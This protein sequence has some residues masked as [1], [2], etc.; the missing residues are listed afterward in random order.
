MSQFFIIHPQNPQARLIQQ[1]VDIL[2]KGGIIV[3]PTD[4]GYAIG[5]QLENKDGADRIRNIRQLSADHNFTLVCRN[6]SQLSVYASVDNV[7][8]RLL[9][10]NT[11][12]A[13]TF[14][15]NATKEVPK[16]LVHARRKTIGIRI[17]DSEIIQTL[18]L[19]L[20]EPLMS[21][22]LI[23]PN[24]EYPFSDAQDILEHLN[25]QVDLVIDGGS[26]GVTP[27]T[28]IELV[29]SAPKILRIGKGDPRIFL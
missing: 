15:L 12:G 18:L 23:L 28:M 29:G 5:C 9:K 27:T 21:V 22:S 11:P 19:K 13:Y 10:A 8:F 20:E 6:L 25:K 26:C 7:A 16:R 4:S 17:P 14:I 2:K 1:T 24:Q 3:Y